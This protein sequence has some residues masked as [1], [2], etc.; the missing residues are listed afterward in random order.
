MQPLPSLPGF[1]EFDILQQL[2]ERDR[3]RHLRVQN[4]TKI[5]YLGN[6]LPLP[7]LTLGRSDHAPAIA[8][9][10]GVHGLERIGSQVVLAFLDTLLSRLEWDSLYEDLLQQVTIHFIP[11]LNPA[12]MLAHT[13]ANGNGVDLMRNAPIDSCEKTVWLAG[14][15]RISPKLPWYRGIADQ[16]METEA[17]ALCDFIRSEVLPAPF[18]LVLDCHSGFGHHNQIWFPYAHSRQQAIPNLGEVYYL[19]QLFFQT[20][21]YQSYHF[22]P[23][24]QHYLTHGDLWDYLYLDALDQNSMFLP[25]TLE[26]GSWRWVRKNPRQLF[27]RL[28]LYHPIKTHRINRVL[29]GHL[30]LMEFLLHAALSYRKWLDQSLTGRMHQEALELWYARP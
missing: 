28:G 3:G 10:G 27:N 20:Y 19:R 16:P 2:I 6:S 22:E 5:N 7:A 17:Q 14:G 26:M 1:P 9:I 4:L 21:P 18:S 25:L 30:V 8:F 24:S 12:G 29:R 15:H 13:R 11:V 23:Q